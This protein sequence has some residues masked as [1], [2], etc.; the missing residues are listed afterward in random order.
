V[1]VVVPSGAR[2]DALATFLAGLADADGHGAGPTGP[3]LVNPVR[4]DD[5]QAAK[6]ATTTTN[7]RITTLP[8]RYVSDPPADLGS[9][10]DDLRDAR[11]SYDGLTSLV[12]N[13]LDV[14]A[15]VGALLLSSGARDLDDAGR[16]AVLGAAQDDT[17]DITGDIVVAPEQVVTLTSSSG[18]VPLNLENRL[19]VPVVVQ[20][21]MSSAK[22]DFPEGAVV[23]DIT[24]N[25]AQTTTITLPVE[26]RASGAFPLTITIASADGALPVATTRYTVRSTAIS[27]IGLV[28]SIGAGL[29]LLIWWGRHFRTARRARKLVGGDDDGATGGQSNDDDGPTGDQ[30]DDYAPTHGENTR[31][32]LS[33]EG[34]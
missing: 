32:P 12:P 8:R 18:Q 4:L 3:P 6:A 13:N 1:A 5:L 31:E 30:P 19:P 2:P 22:L 9:Y 34:R 11:T 15:P 14:Y 26:T 7:G 27:G 17:T 33:T 16:S 23:S 24:L 21:R 29:F 28:L 25:A 20:V 10:P